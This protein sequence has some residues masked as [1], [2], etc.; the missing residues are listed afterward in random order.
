MAFHRF[1]KAIIDQEPVCLYGDGL[2]TR[3]FTYVSDIVGANIRA[4]SADGVVGK[5]MNVAGG[6]RVT[7]RHVLEL[8]GEIS[9]LPV[10]IAYLPDQYGDVRHTFADIT[11]A[12]QLIDYVPRVSLREGLAREFEDIVSLY[13]S[14]RAAAA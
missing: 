13:A 7:M 4:A 3:D 6:S 10:E 1:C 5:V 9:G 2:Q 14:I 11:R 12:E 8:L